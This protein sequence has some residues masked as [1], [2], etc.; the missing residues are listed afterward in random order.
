MSER[1][2]FLEVTRDMLCAVIPLESYADCSE[3]LSMFFAGL[4]A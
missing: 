4:P 1:V 2:Y 3:S